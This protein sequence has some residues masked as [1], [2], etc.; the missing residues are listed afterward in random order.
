MIFQMSNK[1]FISTKQKIID[2]KRDFEKLQTSLLE[3]EKKLQKAQ[4]DL[5]ELKE[6]HNR[7][8]EGKHQEIIKEKQNSRELNDKLESMRNEH[9]Q[10]MTQIAELNSRVESLRRALEEARDNNG[11]LGGFFTGLAAGALAAFGRPSD[12]RLK[13]NITAL[14]SSQYHCLGLRGVQWV[15]EKAASEFGLMGAGRGLIAQ[16][17]ETL[18]PDAVVTGSD[19]YKRVN[20]GLLM[21]YREQFCHV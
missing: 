5:V 13:Q 19:G 8:M 1:V 3:E 9:T 21:I 14:T 17:V 20:Y 11:G 2:N 7:D 18:Y 4:Q 12:V 6:K 10:V 15:W 16:E